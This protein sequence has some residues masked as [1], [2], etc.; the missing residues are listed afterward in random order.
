[1]HATLQGCFI[2]PDDPRWVGALEQVPH[3]VYHTPAY[4]T[5]EAD[6]LTAQPAAFLVADGDRVAFVPLLLRAV[7][8]HAGTACD[9]VSPYGYPGIVY[10]PAASA[11][12]GFLDDFIDALG[13]ALGEEGVCSAFIRLHPLLTA[14]LPARLRRH[15]VVD[16]GVTVSID[17]TLSTERLWATMRKGHTN[18]VNKAR[19]AG[20]RVEIGRTPDYVEAFTSVYSETVDRLRASA[21]YDYSA[22]YLRR[23]ID[24]DDARLAVALLGDD[25]AAAYL[26]F[27]RNGIVQMHLGGTR[28]AYM[29]PSPSNL[30]I[31]SIALW[32]KAR[33][34]HS[35]HLGGGV[36]G[37]GSD[38]LFTFKSG[39]SPRRHAFATLRLVID[40]DRY[41]G[42]VTQRADHLGVPPDVLA[43][44]DF[45]PA[46][47]ATI[48]DDGTV[49]GER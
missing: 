3:D 2:S 37:S 30:L 33:G 10:S 17:L 40:P 43:A 27:E 22:D 6:R 34:N 4:V 49:G 20:F 39:F 19:R 21:G 23:L 15:A 42:L 44:S 12:P 31:H 11:Q 9:G 32:A 16:N 24:L 29:R 18:A 14:E 25:V 7:P 35:V 41:D 26:F 1:M 38:S 5:A 36:G 47:R 28:A 13:T 45:F 48:G 8:G 46:Y